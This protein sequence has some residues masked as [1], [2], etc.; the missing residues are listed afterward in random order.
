MAS[1]LHPISGH[2]EKDN[3]GLIKTK[4]KDKANHNIEKPRY[5]QP[6]PLGVWSTGSGL[7]FNDISR[8][9]VSPGRLCLADVKQKH[10]KVN[11]FS[12]AHFSS[13]TGWPGVKTGSEPCPV[14]INTSANVRPATAMWV[15]TILS[16]YTPVSSESSAY[17]PLPPPAR[18][19]RDVTR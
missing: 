11:I 17:S 2:G 8:P 7:I 6:H 9:S 14:N 10:G 13:R 15:F 1:P 16:Q 5:T 3:R 4:R 18:C 19:L 12:A